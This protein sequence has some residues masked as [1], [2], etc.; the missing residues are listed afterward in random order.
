MSSNLSVL[1]INNKSIH[2]EK[3]EQ[4]KDSSSHNNSH[5]LRIQKMDDDEFEEEKTDYLNLHKKPK[6]INPNPITLENN[7]YK[8][9]KES[10]SPSE[11]KP[12]I[13]NT[14]QNDA[15]IIVTERNKIANSEDEKIEMNKYCLICESE[16]VFDELNNNFIECFHGFCDSCY[17]DY[18][19]EKIINNDVEN[20]KCPQKGCQTILDEF[21]IKNHLQNDT[22]LLDKYEKFKQRKKLA[23]DPNMQLCPFPN[24]ESYAKK[25]PITLNV[26]CL[27]GHKFCFNC[28]KD[29]H[30]NEKCK[31]ENDAK[32]ENWR[33][34]RKVK[35]CPNCNFFIEKNDGCNHMTCT[36]CK[37]EWCW[38]CL[39]E[40][41]PGH[42]DQGGQCEGLQYSNCPCI[43][44]KFC[45]FLY[46]IPFHIFE[47]LK[48][49][50]IFPVVFYV[51]IFKIVKDINYHDDFCI[52]RL[53]R[54][55]IIFF[56]CL[57]F[58]VYATSMM[59]LIF[60]LAIFCFPFKRFIS[61]KFDEILD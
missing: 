11:N 16:L 18:L 21:F 43:S 33:N 6:V 50:G 61:E 49:F 59:T 3:I 8:E 13:I 56:Y 57:C 42:Y 55:F 46:R 40:S 26:T 35:R 60:I 23:K 34:S 51:A 27:E 44:N 15:H 32:F 19:K 10:E 29:W 1:S 12:N 7:L 14:H 17:Y 31:I 22:S 36:N 54:I 39:Q 30:G 9:E 2:I 58:F 41:L 45:A 37:Y 52:Y 24:C 5:S 48:L 53:A 20:I 28:L 47:C 25:N 38:I 4:K